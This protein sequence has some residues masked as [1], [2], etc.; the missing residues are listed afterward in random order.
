MNYIHI[1]IYFTITSFYF[2]FLNEMASNS[3]FTWS[4]AST[5]GYLSLFSS[6]RN[7]PSGCSSWSLCMW[8]KQVLLTRH[9]DLDSFCLVSI[10][11]TVASDI[12]TS[13]NPA[14]IYPPN[15][16]Y[17]DTL[18]K[19]RYVIYKEFT[20]DWLYSKIIISDNI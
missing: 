14:V 10:A 18:L 7:N 11:F 8:P 20:I 9:S 13:W 15:I 2:I 19:A 5:G 16:V 12:T 3:V 6:L 4:P 17:H 1:N